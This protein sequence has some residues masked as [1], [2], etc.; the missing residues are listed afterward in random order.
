MPIGWCLLQMTTLL[1]HLWFTINILKSSLQPAHQISYLGVK[2]DSTTMKFHLIKEQIRT[3]CSQ[4]LIKRKLSAQDLASIIGK[5]SASRSAVLP[6]PIYLHQLQ[7]QLIQTL[8]TAHLFQTILTLSN[9]SEE[10][11]LWWILHLHDWNGRDIIPLHR[12]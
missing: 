4:A 3:V 5:L 11:L 9:K 7:H 12:I 2:V 10:E 8:K 1:D 6:A